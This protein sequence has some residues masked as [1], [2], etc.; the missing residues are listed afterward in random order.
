MKK[1]QTRISQKKLQT[2]I[3]SVANIEYREY[4]GEKTAVYV[5]K[6]DGSYMTF[7]GLGNDLKMYYKL[8]ITEQ[9]QGMP[10]SN[11]DGT[12]CIG[13]NPTE[14]KWYGWS[15]RAIYGFGI[16]STCKQ[17]DCHFKPGNV[18]EFMKACLDFWGDA[19]YSCGDDTAV[20]T[21]SLDHDDKTEVEG[22]L[23][24]YTYNDKVPNEKLRGTKYEHFSPFPK[25]W[26]KGEWTAKTMEDAKQMA[27]DF[28]DGVS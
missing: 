9:L 13:F 7:V 11:G 20:V 18:N 15:H 25:E 23:V 24:S 8:G 2:W 10:E 26:G 21:K 27:I 16:D 28:A 12:T 5:S 22:V 1:K 14:N 6:I 4:A 17:G 19:E 3:D